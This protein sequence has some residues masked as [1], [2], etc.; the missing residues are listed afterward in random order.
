MTER[1]ERM[2]S[3]DGGFPAEEVV[4][5]SSSQRLPNGALLALPQAVE[6][7]NDTSSKKSTVL[8]VLRT[9]SS[10]LAHKDGDK[11]SSFP[12]VLF[13]LECNFL[14]KPFSATLLLF[15]YFQ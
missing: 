9:Y 2:C 14:V 12:P 13:S 4:G 11:V 1:W 5:W 10:N 6:R 8:L 7:Y 3:F 15:L